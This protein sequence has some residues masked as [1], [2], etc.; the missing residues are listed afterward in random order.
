MKN[1]TATL[2]V[3]LV[4]LLLPWLAFSQEARAPVYKD[5][6]WWKVKY[7]LKSGSPRDSCSW[8]YSEYIVKIK[9]GKPKVYGISG[10]KQEEF[11]C[12]GVAAR[13]LGTGSNARENLKFPLRVGNSWKNRF[14]RSKARRG[15]GRWHYPEYKVLGWEKVKTP[16]GEF[17]AFKLTRFYSAAS[18]RSTREF[19]ATY[20]YSPKV[21][22]I[23]FIHSKSHS[24]ERTTTIID[25]KVSE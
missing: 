20:Y 4:V 9:K 16:K 18:L 13:V 23:I 10:A 19:A 6:D 15:R 5:G 11:E 14:L 2:T 17:E 8:E 12:P 7:E 25:F 3:V 21:K 24:R 1:V 22:A